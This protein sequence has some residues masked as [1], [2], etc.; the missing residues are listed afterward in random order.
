MGYLNHA[1]KRDGLVLGL[2][3]LIVYGLA[4]YFDGSDFIVEFLQRHENWQADELILAILTAG[5]MGFVYAWRR[6]IELRD[7][8]QNRNLAEGKAL[9]L[10]YHDPLTRLPNR[11]FLD[12]R[13][14]DGNWGSKQVGSMIAIDLDGF[15]KVNDLVGHNGGDELLMIISQRL[16]KTCQLEIIIRVGGDEFLLV[17]PSTEVD[18]Q[19]LCERVRQELS[20]PMII[21]GIQVE[22]GASIGLAALANNGSLHDTMLHADLAMYTAKRQGRNS[23]CAYDPHQWSAKA[24]RVAIEI[25][26][27]KAI[28]ERRIVT[29]YQPIIDME[30]GTVLGFEALARW[31]LADG[32]TIPPVIFIGIAEEAGLITELSEQL[33]LQACKDAKT[34]PSEIFLA[35][36]LSATQLGDR[37]LGSRIINVLSATGLPAERL[38]ME[39]TESAVMR[40]LASALAVL[41]ELR[42]VGIRI[43]IDDFGTGFSS[44]SQLANLPFDKIKIDGS[45]INSFEANEKQAKIVRSIVSLGRGLG[46]QTTAEGVE[47]GSQYEHLKQI[48]CEQGQGF[49]FGKAMPAGA[50]LGFLTDQTGAA[51]IIPTN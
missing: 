30:S 29:H 18:A 50:V 43:A 11:H 6:L 2:G 17:T 10:A 12:A 7:E 28:S 3:G 14:A 24:E 36:N 15:K 40:D 49:L 35:Y 38:E 41:E 16:R 37:L 19:E 39:V 25:E 33:L 26:L 51:L 44:L 34:W 45:F 8:T 13:L 4:Y 22:V 47:L 1:A 42:S 23:I 32:T 27:R 21:D 5:L 31:T 20:A 46:V 48:G 9:W